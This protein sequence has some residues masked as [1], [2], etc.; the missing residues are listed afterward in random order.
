MIGLLW[1]ST[2][3]KQPAPQHKQKEKIMLNSPKPV[4]NGT[5][6]NHPYPGIPT[7]DDS[8][9]PLHDRHAIE[10][11]GRNT[12]HG[13]WGRTDTINYTDPTNPHGQKLEGWKAF[14]TIP[15][16]PE[17]A[18]LV[19]YHPHLGYTVE[20]H[21]DETVTDAYDNELVYKDG[22]IF[23]NGGYFYDGTDWNRPYLRTSHTKGTQYAEPVPDA[24]T[25]TALDLNPTTDTAPVFTVAQIATGTPTKVTES[26]WENTGF[27]AWKKGQH[28]NPSTAIPA[29]MSIIGFTSPET[30]PANMLGS[31]ELA[32]ELG[33]TP[34][35]L[36]TQRHRHQLPTPQIQGR[37]NMWSRPV[38]ERYKNRWVKPQ[39]PTLPELDTNDRL[40]E[41]ITDDLTVEITPKTLKDRIRNVFRARPEHYQ[42]V[43]ILRRY[44]NGLNTNGDT[45]T[46]LYSASLFTDFLRYRRYDRSPMAHH[47]APSIKTT[48]ELLSL[49]VLNPETA[50]SVVRDFMSVV[51]GYAEREADANISKLWEVNSAEEAEIITNEMRKIFYDRIKSEKAEVIDMA[52]TFIK[53]VS[54]QHLATFIEEAL[55]DQ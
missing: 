46:S 4:A 32:G 44:T 30:E 50:A 11:I 25:V 36:R 33:I 16:H 35:T 10:A 8:A 34:A 17:Y 9:L 26:N 23:R 47:H 41:R 7:V 2:A 12:K 31:E 49:A 42:I 14:T 53:N 13:L 24:H 54:D 28:N 21:E 48:N 29:D 43:H 18:W 39:E 22:F 37:K 27:A 51:R 52:E 5:R 20:L 55:Q 45:T 38:I 6:T 19:F 1:Y 3:E 40:Y 15:E